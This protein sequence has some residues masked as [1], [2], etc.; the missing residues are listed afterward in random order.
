M[1][2]SNNNNNKIIKNNNNNNNSL[3]IIMNRIKRFSKHDK[4]FHVWSIQFVS[5]KLEECLNQPYVS[6]Y[7]TVMTVAILA[8][9][10]VRWE[11]NYE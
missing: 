3:K 6:N 8:S 4:K 1:I 11:C 5:Y 10:A 2:K 9:K 7:H